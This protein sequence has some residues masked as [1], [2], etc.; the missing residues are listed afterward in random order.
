[1]ANDAHDWTF[2]GMADR[3]LAHLVAICSRCGVIRTSPLPGPGRQRHI[4]LRGSCPGAPQP[5]ESDTAEGTIG[6]VT[7]DA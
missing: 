5:P 4:D 6:L 7:Q 2:T 1:M 3:D